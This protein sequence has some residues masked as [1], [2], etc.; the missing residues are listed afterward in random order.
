MNID[1]GCAKFWR[2]FSDMFLGL[3]CCTQVFRI[4]L[5]S[6]ARRTDLEGDFR[7]TCPVIVHVERHKS[8]HGDIEADIPSRVKAGVRVL[9]RLNRDKTDDKGAHTRNWIPGDRSPKRYPLYLS[10]ANSTA[11][12]NTHVKSGPNFE[13]LHDLAIT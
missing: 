6:N 5:D 13:P 10:L 9:R 7:I 1:L 4:Y 11:P 3:T 2:S 12:L 8:E